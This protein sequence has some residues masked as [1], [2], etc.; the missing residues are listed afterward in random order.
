VP[1]VGIL[2]VLSS[3]SF[4]DSIGFSH[5]VGEIQNGTPDTVTFVQASATFYDKN[6]RVVGTGFGYTNPTD[7]GPGDKAPFEIILSSSSVPAKQISHYRV[8]VSHD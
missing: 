6:N 5:I 1:V 2:K 4:V 7:L 3:N 8:T